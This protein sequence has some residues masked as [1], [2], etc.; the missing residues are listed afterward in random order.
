MAGTGTTHLRPDQAPRLVA[1]DVTVELG[2]RHARARA[3]SGVSLDVLD[4]ETVGVV[5]ESGCGKTTLLRAV[6]QLVP[7]AGGS[8]RLDGTE[9][10]GLGERD[11]RRHRPA[12]QMLFQDP[13]SALNPRRAVH[14]LLAEGAVMAGRARPDDDRIAAALDEVGLDPDA[15]WDRRRGSLSGGQCQ[16]VNLARALLIEPR[17]LLCDEPVS[18][19]DVSVQAQILNLVA[20]VRRDRDISVVFVAHDLAVV[21]YVSDRVVVMYLGKVCEVAP[22]DAVF[23]TPAH[24]YTAL[25]RS[26]VV[27]LGDDD[28]DGV[29]A[30]ADDEP[31]S[32]LDPPSGCRFRT[33]C[34][35]A[36]AVC[37]SDEPVLVEVA[38]GHHVA[39]HHPL[40]GPAAP[41]PPP[42]SWAAAPSPPPVSRAAAPSPPPVSRAA[43]PSPPPAAVPVAPPERRLD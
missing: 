24:P 14:Q 21:R 15:V 11:M 7:V 36:D 20:Q 42:A 33:R 9:L 38:P 41:S 40:D 19:L 6:L 32:P 4:G 1:E 28:P 10:T 12:L 35:R 2:P 31:P 18:A 13:V 23:A 17:V 43:A 37:A 5:G 39:C 27:E 25:L 34:P 30:S 22:P 29:A 26:S 3:V 8:V 16:R